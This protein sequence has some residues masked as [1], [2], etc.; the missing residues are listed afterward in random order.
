[1][2]NS[3]A[4]RFRVLVKSVA[5]VSRVLLCCLR[6]VTGIY[7]NFLSEKGKRFYPV[8]FSAMSRMRPRRFS[9]P[10]LS[11][12]NLPYP[13]TRV[14]VMHEGD[15]TGEFAREEATQEKIMMAAIGGTNHE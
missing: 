7:E 4:G 14:Y 6:I 8:N 2:E 3:V 13:R 9:P 1:M 10:K 12:R 15:L 11:T 5:I